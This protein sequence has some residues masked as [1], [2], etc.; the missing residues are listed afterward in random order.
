MTSTSEVASCIGSARVCF[1]CACYVLLQVN[2][3]A[4]HVKGSRVCVSSVVLCESIGE[5][6]KSLSRFTEKRILEEYGQ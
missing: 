3:F 5:K 2:L 4:S 6:E 1:R